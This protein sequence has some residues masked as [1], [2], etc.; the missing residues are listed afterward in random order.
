MNHVIRIGTRA[1]ALATWQARW[2]AQRL[3]LAGQKSELVAISTRGDENTEKSIETLGA[4][5][6]FV[7]ELQK[8]LLD[9]R[10]DMAVH[11]LK[12]LPTEPVKEPHLGGCAR[13]RK[14]ARRIG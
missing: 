3:D 2:V 13:A 1:S 12:D 14:S 5:G 9:G 7:K 4:D 10:I 6:V 8:P 11:S